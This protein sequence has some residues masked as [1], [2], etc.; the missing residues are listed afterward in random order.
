MK[1]SRFSEEQIVGVLKGGGGRGP[2]EGSL[3]NGEPHTQRLRIALNPTFSSMRL[4]TMAESVSA[5]GPTHT[6]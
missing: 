4:A 5:Y 3:P 2:G 6:R 1:K